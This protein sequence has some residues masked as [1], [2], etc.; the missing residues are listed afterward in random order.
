MH[1]APKSMIYL[2]IFWL[3]VFVL[4]TKLGGKE[5]TEA[6]KAEIVNRRA[7]K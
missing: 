3:F 1:Q 6:E 7:G 5:L 4:F 2:P